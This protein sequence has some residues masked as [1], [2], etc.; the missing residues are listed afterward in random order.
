M[1]DEQFALCGQV[2]QESSVVLMG[3]PRKDARAPGGFELDV[4]HFQVVQ[5]SE[6]FP[7]QPKEHGTG[8]FNGASAFVAALKPPTCHFTNPS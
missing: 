1:G 7:I 2:T 8:V 3:Q 4:A 6:P 5:L